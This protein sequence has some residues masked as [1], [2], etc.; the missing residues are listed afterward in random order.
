MVYRM[1][2]RLARN[3]TRWKELNPET[4]T[5]SRSGETDQEITA[6]PILLQAEDF[7]ESIGMTRTEYQQWGIDVNDYRF[8]AVGPSD[9]PQDGDYITR[10]DGSVFK[11]VP[12]G[13]HSRFRTNTTESEYT[14]SARTRFLVTTVMVDYDS[15]SA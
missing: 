11:V 12:A 8:N 13:G 1:Q 9:F 4:V 6:S 3:G 10:A 5:L 7:I 2:D 15:P 14:T